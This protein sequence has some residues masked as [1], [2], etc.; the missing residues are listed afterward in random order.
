VTNIAALLIAVPMCRQRG[1]HA[2]VRQADALVLRAAFDVECIV[3]LGWATATWKRESCN[4]A[5]ANDEQSQ[6]QIYILLSHLFTE[7]VLN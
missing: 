4:E 7:S 5:T 6:Q 2:D 1:A 3:A